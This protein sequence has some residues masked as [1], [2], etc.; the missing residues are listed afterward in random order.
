[1]SSDAKEIHIRIEDNGSG[2]DKDDL[3]HLFEDFFRVENSRNRETGGSGLGLSIF[4][5]S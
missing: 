1:M 4:K 5:K 3:P 2:V